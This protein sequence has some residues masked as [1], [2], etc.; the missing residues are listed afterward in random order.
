MYGVAVKSEHVPVPVLLD[1]ELSRLDLSEADRQLALERFDAQQA[2]RGNL[3][4]PVPVKPKVSG[5]KAALRGL[6]AGGAVLLL[7]VIG[8]FGYWVYYATSAGDAFDSI[9]I[10]INNLMPQPLNDWAC[11]QLYQRFGNERA[12]F[13]CVSTE[14]WTSWKV[15][16]TKVKS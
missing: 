4:Q 1:R 9:G 10:E 16:P 7:M 6:L 8:I 5:G 12:P 2:T 14:D 11:T 3:V 13:G 15:A